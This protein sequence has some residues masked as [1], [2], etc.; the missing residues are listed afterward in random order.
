MSIA[1][2]AAAGVVVLGLLVAAASAD[3]A[4]RAEAT[5]SMRDALRDLGVRA[6]IH[7]RE[8]EEYAVGCHGGTTVSTERGVAGWIANAETPECRIRAN[9]WLAE[10]D[11][12]RADLAAEREVAR[13]AG[14]L[15]G[16]V[17]DAVKRNR[18]D[19]YTSPR[20]EP[21]FHGGEM[22]RP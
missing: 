22:P 7:E 11:A 8:V 14:V 4:A 21:P 15:P 13:R 17:R 3:D 12:L 9:R 6:R 20:P 10:D 1:R 18:L 16:A 2:I 5:D 19:D